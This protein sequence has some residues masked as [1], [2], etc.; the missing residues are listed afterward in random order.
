MAHFP[1]TPSFTGFST[2]S[3]IEADAGDLQVVGSTPR[4]IDGA[5]YRVA[6]DHPGRTGPARRRASD[7]RLQWTRH[8]PAGA[9]R[10][11]HIGQQVGGVGLFQRYH[12]LP[13]HF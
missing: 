5:F 7:V 3:R 6:A 10:C 2:P 1:D 11:I 4:E 9:D 8:G 13:R 12:N